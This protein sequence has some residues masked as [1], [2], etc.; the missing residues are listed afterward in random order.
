MFCFCTKRICNWSR[1]IINT[2]IVEGMG[3]RKK[4]VRF[5][6]LQI[7][8]AENC[9]IIFL[10]YISLFLIFKE[11]WIAGNVKGTER[12]F[13]TKIWNDDSKL[14]SRFTIYFLV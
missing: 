8:K 13:D 1:W 14:I 10:N 9:L 11:K 4:S 6:F 5:Y 7:A 12:H 3:G 2:K